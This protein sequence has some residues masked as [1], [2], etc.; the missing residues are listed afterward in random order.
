MN[1]F[2]QAAADAD[3]ENTKLNQNF[4]G[5]MN[6]VIALGTDDPRFIELG[7]QWMAGIL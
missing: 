5:I 1:A 7:K 2:I 6:T 4:A 3:F